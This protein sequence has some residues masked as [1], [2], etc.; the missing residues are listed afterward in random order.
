MDASNAVATE[1]SSHSCDF[2][3]GIVQQLIQPTVE[4]VGRRPPLFSLV[5]PIQVGWLD[6]IM[7][8]QLCS[9]CRF[10]TRIHDAIKL[11]ADQSVSGQRRL[12]CHI[13]GQQIRLTKS[14]KR[15]DWNLLFMFGSPEDGNDERMDSLYEPV[16]RLYSGDAHLLGLHEN[17]YNLG[18]TTN[19]DK[20]DLQLIKSY[21][22]ECRQLHGAKCEYPSR[23]I[24]GKRVTLWTRM[25][26]PS[27]M[28]FVDVQDNCVKP[29]WP[30]PDY[31]A[32]SYMWGGV[33]MIKLT[34]ANLRGMEMPGSLLN[35][36]LPR[37][38]RDAISVTRA[39]G[40]RYI[41]ID[42]VCICQ[43]DM[44]TKMDQIQQMDKI[45]SNATLTI[46]AA[47]AD[48]ADAGL[49][50]FRTGSRRHAQVIESIQGLRFVSVAPDIEKVLSM[51]TYSSR[52]WTFQEYVLSKR[53]LVF[54]PF[55]VYY[56]CGVN[57]CSEDFLYRLAP[58]GDD[59]TDGTSND[60]AEGQGDLDGRALHF[61][62]NFPSS[63]ESVVSQYSQRRLTYEA[64][65][66][67][68][69]LG[70]LNLM[71]TTLNETFI[72]GIPKS[73]I[74]EHGLLWLPSDH[75]MRRR[76][77]S[78]PE[79]STLF[80][81]WSWIGWVGPVRYVIGALL[82]EDQRAIDDAR[83]IGSWSARLPQG[84]HRRTR[85]ECSNAGQ[86]GSSCGSKY[87]IHPL[88]NYTKTCCPRCT[89][90]GD[91]TPMMTMLPMHKKASSASPQTLWN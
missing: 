79:G 31:V 53:L 50:C 24:V 14:G 40:E 88:E 32:L 61:E 77:S 25:S 47:G 44:D 13:S 30:Q 82:G 41:W 28:R 68:A 65:V 20:Y 90:H 38:I 59:S 64:D 87:D 76:E 4:S 37:T 91:Q 1:D 3:K 5:K 2:C 45:Y 21:Y 78:S 89:D 73:C 36:N 56:S 22:D 72:C 10:I 55:Q 81:S 67:P 33:D 8:N 70:I 58:E 86:G 18:L 75:R 63:Y 52:G 16:C 39:L 57:T 42:A 26:L 54:T 35:V 11:P 80:P 85:F 27:A 69:V 7:K 83:E 34:K 9:L 48:H 66:I 74:F 84:K 29:V 43:D 6:S 51:C 15:R 71:S 46:I 60:D 62:Q 12:Y 23:T 17:I 49:P 19:P